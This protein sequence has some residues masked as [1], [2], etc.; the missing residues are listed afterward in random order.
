MDREPHPQITIQTDFYASERIPSNIKEFY[1]KS[2][3]SFIKLSAVQKKNL[4][5]YL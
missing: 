2:S 4:S 3:N 1:R 5:A